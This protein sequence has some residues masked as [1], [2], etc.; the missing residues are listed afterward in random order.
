MRVLHVDDDLGPFFARGGK[1]LFYIG[2]NDGHNP[3]ELIDYYQRLMARGGSATQQSAR[4]FTIP[5]MGHC[6]GGAGCDTFDK[7]GAIDAWVAGEK[8]PEAIE[9]R[10]VSGGKVVRSR[11]ICAWPAFARW[12][13]RGRMDDAASFSCVSSSEI[14]ARK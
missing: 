2:W 12:N 3:E 11:P 5:G 7:L 8:A 10:K 1:L 6:L 9:S 13:G 14:L 4:L